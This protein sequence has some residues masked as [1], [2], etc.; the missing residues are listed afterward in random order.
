MSSFQVLVR[1]GQGRA[2]QKGG[3][4]VACFKIRPLTTARNALVG[5]YCD[6]PI[7][8]A[9]RHDAAAEKKRA[10]ALCPGCQVKHIFCTSYTLCHSH[11]D[12]AN[13]GL[14]MGRSVQQRNQILRTHAL[15][16]ITQD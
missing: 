14:G 12:L 13:L 16:N 9:L 2:N 11:H 15:E 8:I 5:I 7:V 6:R 4:P 1:S 3:M 10:R